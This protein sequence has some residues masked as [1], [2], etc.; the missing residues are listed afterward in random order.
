MP[1]H[2]R[3]ALPR[4]PPRSL[5]APSVDLDGLGKSLATHEA[6]LDEHACVVQVLAKDLR[7]VCGLVEEVVK[8]M[9]QAGPGGALRGGPLQDTAAAM[10]SIHER[11]APGQDAGCIVQCMPRWRHLWGPA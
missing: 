8:A 5:Q 11:C 10:E 4:R 9:G 1:L 6:L 2:P 7:S 3:D